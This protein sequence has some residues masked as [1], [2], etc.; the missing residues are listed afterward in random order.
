MEL[1]E[2]VGQLAVIDREIEQLRT[3]RARAINVADFREVNRL[4]EAIGCLINAQDELRRCSRA[5][6][7]W[8]FTKATE[9]ARSWFPLPH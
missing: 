3:R 9:R 4:M 2:V 7:W 5:R 8:R 1:P 6:R